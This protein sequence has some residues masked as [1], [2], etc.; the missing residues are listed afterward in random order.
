M[1]RFKL[2]LLLSVVVC[3]AQWTGGAASSRADVHWTYTGETGP[4]HWSEI[5]PTS[6]CMGQSQSPVNII[7]T[8]T[9]PVVSEAWPLEL[10][11]PKS[12]LL[13][14]VTNDGHSIKY[15]FEQGDE[16]A[17]RGNRYGLV[18]LHFHEPSEHTLNGVRYPI[19]MH[20]VH[21]SKE[22]SRYTVLSVLG[23]E[24]KPSPGYDWLE[25]Y[26]P[27]SPGQSKRIE[28]PFDLSS[29][30]PAT[31]TPR[32]HYEGSLTTPPCSENVSW[33]VFERPFMLSEGQ[34]N[35]LKRNM[36]TNNY[37]G[38]QPLRGRTVSLVVH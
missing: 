7:R 4:E 11:Y 25:S 38:V 1:M 29:V 33:V 23:Y 10:H 36:P 5:E 9:S 24:G 12:T 20:M 16:I 22:L 15:D 32:F 17:F 18:Q 30:L 19:E 14:T 26:L 27:L 3:V 21:F 28:Q 8:A 6:E 31:L 2:S 13:R 34:V 37:R 35:L